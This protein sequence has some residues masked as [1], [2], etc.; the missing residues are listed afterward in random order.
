MSSLHNEQGTGV[1]QVTSSSE[2]SSSGSES[3]SSSESIKFDDGL[4][5]ELV[6]DE[7]DR[8][9]LAQMTEAERE[10]EMYNRYVCKK[11]PAPTCGGLTTYFIGFFT[12]RFL[13]CT[14][15][16]VYF[17]VHCPFSFTPFG[18]FLPV[19]VSG[20]ISSSILFLSDLKNV[21]L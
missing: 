5:D 16:S 7:D 19:T 3:S 8:V 1:S 14:N 18:P 15:Q 17:V 13:Y 6:G 12:C 9:K 20:Y 10:Q 4:D 21:R 11:Q 2:S